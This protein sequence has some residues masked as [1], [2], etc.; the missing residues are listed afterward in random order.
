MKIKQEQAMTDEEFRVFSELA[1]AYRI[2]R[3]AYH[4]DMHRE[5]P[6]SNALQERVGEIIAAHSVS[7]PRP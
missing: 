4:H 6:P 2:I 3:E 5:Q 1:E 7:V